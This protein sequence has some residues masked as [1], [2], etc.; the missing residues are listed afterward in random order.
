[1]KS[2]IK[3]LRILYFIIII[4]GFLLFFYYQNNNTIEIENENYNY[5]IKNIEENKDFVEYEINVDTKYSDEILVKI[6]NEIKEDYIHLYKINEVTD[7]V[8]TFNIKFYYRNELLK[9]F[10]N[11]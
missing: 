9:E 3:I 4:I 8:D 1:M 6:C 11:K 2:E 10:G 7:K 5:E